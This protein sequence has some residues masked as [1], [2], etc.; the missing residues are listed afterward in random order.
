MWSSKITAEKKSK[1]GGNF[2]SAKW[3][4]QNTFSAGCVDWLNAWESL[5]NMI[6]LVLFFI[7][8]P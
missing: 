1:H 7:D 4:W 6:W 5:I 2:G 8:Q 3:F